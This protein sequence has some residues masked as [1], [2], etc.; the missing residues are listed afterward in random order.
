MAI[1]KSFSNPIH[2]GDFSDSGDSDMGR[3]MVVSTQPLEGL[4]TIILTYPDGTEVDTGML[5]I[6]GRALK[7][8]LRQGYKVRRDFFKK[9]QS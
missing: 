3:A 8:W 2:C 6:S 9:E 1:G 7:A 5:R 4:K